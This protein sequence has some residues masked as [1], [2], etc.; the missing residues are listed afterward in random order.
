MTEAV[1]ETG[2]LQEDLLSREDQI[3]KDEP[4]AISKRGDE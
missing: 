1:L 2:S 3:S 4:S